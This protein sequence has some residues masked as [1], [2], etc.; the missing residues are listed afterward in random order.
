MALDTSRGRLFVGEHGNCRVMVFDVNAITNGENAIHV[1]GQS[2]FT[3]ATAATSQ[4]GLRNPSGVAI[5]VGGTFYLLT[6]HLGSVVTVLDAPGAVVGEQR[7]RPFGQPRLTPGITQ[8]DR[9]FTGQR[10]QSAAGLQDFNARWFD[11]SLGAFA[12]PDSLVQYAFSPQALNRYSYVLNNPL[13]YSDPTGHR[14]CEGPMGECWYT[15]PDPNIGTMPVWGWE[16]TVE[17]VGQA[18][19]GLTTVRITG[20]VTPSQREEL[21]RTAA[22]AIQLSGESLSPMIGGSADYAFYAVHGN[23]TI[24]IDPSIQGDLRGA[25]CETT[26]PI[27]SCWAVPPLQTLLHELGHVF[28]VR[29]RQLSGDTHLASDYLPALIVDGLQ[30]RNPTGSTDVRTD[31]G[32][33]CGRPPCQAAQ[34][35]LLTEEYAD[36][37]MNWV[38]DPLQ[39]QYP[40]NGFTGD[41]GEARRDE[42]LHLMRTLWLPGMGFEVIP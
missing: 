11:T 41:Y 10:S 3:R 12:S 26:T 8:T 35:Q 24:N 20:D 7:Y 14:A 17:T 42:W 22:E 16:S 37:Y 40:Q 28:D 30:L 9:G 15:D 13:T 23:F 38:L 19:N 39:E 34:E 29:Y 36:S 25:T 6:D 33:M 32:Y 27:I 2:S 31:F 21:Q 5:D 18:V 1:L 4:T